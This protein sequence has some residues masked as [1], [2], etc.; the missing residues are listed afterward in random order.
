MLHLEFLLHVSLESHQSN[1]L[2]LVCGTGRVFADFFLRGVSRWIDVGCGD[3][4]FLVPLL[5]A[6]KTDLNALPMRHKT[7]SAAT[8]AWQVRFETNA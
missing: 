5:K 6:L 2:F 1:L 4:T 3:P 8:C 7:L